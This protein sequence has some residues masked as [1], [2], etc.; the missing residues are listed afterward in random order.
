MASAGLEPTPDTAVRFVSSKLLCTFY[1]ILNASLCFLLFFFQM[2]SSESSVPT[3]TLSLSGNPS[4]EIV[5]RI[6][7]QMFG[8]HASCRTSIKKHRKKPGWTA[9]FVCLAD[10]NAEKVST[11]HEKEILRKSGLGMKQI[12]FEEEDTE[13]IKKKLMSE[14]KLEGS[15]E[16][17]GFPKL[18]HAGGFELT[19]TPQN[20]RGVVAIDGPYTSKELKIKVGS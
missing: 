3:A 16:I 20:T 8:R 1:I 17:K 12:F 13:E 19:R 14:E 10:N 9:S 6:R 2:V 15:E 4:H 11:F 5:Q 7:N 18:K